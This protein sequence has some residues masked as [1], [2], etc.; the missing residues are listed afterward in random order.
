ML[1]FENVVQL[2]KLIVYHANKYYNDESEISDTEFDDLVKTLKILASSS[3]VLEKVGADVN[4]RELVTHVNKMGTLPK[5]FDLSM[6]KKWGA[7][8]LRVMPKLDG[9]SVECVYE[10]GKLV[11]ASTRGDGE[12][13]EDITQHILQTNARELPHAN[14]SG[15]LYGEFFMKISVFKEKYSED[16]A[17]P[18]NLVAGISHRKDVT[19]AKDCTVLFF[20]GDY[21]ELINS[22]TKD[23]SDY[24][25]PYIKLYSYQI[26]DYV[27]QI[28]DAWKDLPQDGLVWW[29]VLNGED[30]VAFKFPAEVKETLVKD[31][32]WQLS[33]SGKLIP[34]MELEPIELAGTKVSRCTLNNFTWVVNHSIAKG[35][36]VEIQKANEIIPNLVSVV[37]PAL[38]IEIPD[39]CPQCGTK[40]EHLG[41]HLVCPNEDCGDK[42]FTSLVHFWKSLGLKDFGVSFFKTLYDNGVKSYMSSRDLT[43]EDLLAMGITSYTA[44]KFLKRADE[45]W[46]KSSPA[47]FLHGLNINSIGLKTWTKVCEHFDI[48]SCQD[49]VKLTC[50]SVAD[51]SKI[52]GIKSQGSVILEGIQSKL[53]YDLDLGCKYVPEKPMG[54]A[55]KG[56]SFCFTGK[57]NNIKR[58][59][60]EKLVKGLGG[61]ISGVKD[62]LTYLVTNDK[63]SGSSKANKAQE[64]GI[65]I[66]SEQEFLNMVNN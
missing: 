21:D 20:G 28:L 30:R 19:D 31:I 32:T 56:K 40:L 48:D 7:E 1:K 44:R 18:R 10:Q 35:S 62:S 36:I 9:V 2:E 39:I 51:F 65:A 22:V 15:V 53:I 37:K 34:V 58:A 61:K 3:D 27:P 16:Y 46:T 52:E 54:D 55:F 33:K 45:L 47:K 12:R 43:E 23:L 24:M 66:I 8:H 5:V 25:V 64:L 14:F 50:F 29:N 11:S 17:N 57:L 49:T 42:E 26:V 38:N 59:E 41:V 63:D 60:A 13:G 6:L 4:G